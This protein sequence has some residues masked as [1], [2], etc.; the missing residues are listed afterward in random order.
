MASEI[1]HWFGI[2]G[3]ILYVVLLVL[4][5]VASHWFESSDARKAR[6]AGL[7]M[8]YVGG[9]PNA[10]NIAEEMRRRRLL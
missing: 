5:R 9:Y 7:Y 8:I 10:D 3:A 6:I 4:M 1:W 2:G